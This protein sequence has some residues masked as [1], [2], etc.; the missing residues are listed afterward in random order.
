MPSTG[1]LVL[2]LVAA[3]RVR[4]HNSFPLRVALHAVGTDAPSP[5]LSYGF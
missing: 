4:L 5:I 3:Y 1:P 2:P